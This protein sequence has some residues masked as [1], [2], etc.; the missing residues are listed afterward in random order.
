MRSGQYPGDDRLRQGAEVICSTCH[1]AEYRNAVRELKEQQRERL[2]AERQQEREHQRK[3]R[4]EQ[5]KSGSAKSVVAQL[6]TLAKLRK[7]GDIT[8]AEFQDLKARLIS[9][10][11]GDAKPAPPKTSDDGPWNSFLKS[12]QASNE[13]TLRL[14]GGEKEAPLRREQ[15]ENRKTEAKPKSV[16]GQNS[17]STKQPFAV[18]EEVVHKSFGLGVVVTCDGVSHL[19][20]VTVR[21]VGGET[22]KVLAVHL[23]RVG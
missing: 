3:L 4:E 8:E 9:E 5:R 20:S 15:S 7:S 23:K 11:G 17:A 19:S 2:R 16:A 21:F 1:P 6:N 18:G 22:K 13:A 14:L 10:N 12:V